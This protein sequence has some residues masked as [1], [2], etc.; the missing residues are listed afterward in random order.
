VDATPI[1]TAYVEHA[2]PPALRDYVECFWTR[3]AAST[4]NAN[5]HVIPDGCIDLVLTY[6][7][8]GFRESPAA[9]LAVG[10]MTRPLSVGADEAGAYVGVRFWPGRARPFLGIPASEITDLRISLADLSR[11]RD[12]GLVRIHHSELGTWRAGLED[13]LTRQLANAQPIDRT[14]D[15]AVRAIL[16]AGGN[17]AIA[18][19]APAL[20]VTRQHLARAFAV[21][22]GIPPKTFAR[23]ARVRR[24]LA[25]ARVAARVDWAVLALDAGFYDQ[26]HLAG[27]MRELIGR[28]P[29]EWLGT[30]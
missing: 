20:G 13:L 30:L 5:H 14:V 22:V 25:K 12:S 2:P 16:R 28:T 10:T 7:S 1:P 21:H 17:L 23:V 4:P 24:V 8:T 29:T 3:G 6:G 26:A 15:E 9:A 18:A 27:E 11:R 19:L